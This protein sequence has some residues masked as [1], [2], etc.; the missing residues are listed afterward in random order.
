MPARAQ[1]QDASLRP[2]QGP[3][4]LSRWA[5]ALLVAAAVW[6][7][8]SLAAS[9]A[10]RIAYPY[11]LEWMEGAMLAHALRVAEG[12]PLYA[13]PSLEFV[14]FAYVPV[15]PAVVALLSRG[16]GL[17]YV[18]A[19]AVSLGGF[20]LALAAAYAFLRAERSPREIALAGVA[21]PAAAFAP[22][23]ARF[24]LARLDSLFL[25]L[26]AAGL[27]LAWR[28]R[29][30]DGAAVASA[31]VLA[32]AFFTKQTAAPLIVVAA[33]ALRLADRR[34][35]SIFMATLLVAGGTAFALLQAR[36]DGWFAT[37]A[38]GL[39]QRHAF[40]TRA[41]LLVTPLRVGLLLGPGLALVPWAWRTRRS[42][43]L[44]YALALAAAGLAASVLGAGTEWAYNN[45]LIPAV[46]FGGLAIAMAAG[47]LAT[48]PA[49]GRAA[50]VAP[51]ATALSIVSAAG[52]LVWIADRVRPAAGLGL[53]VGYDP[54]PLWPSA[55]D[56]ARGDALVARLRAEPGGVFVPFHPFYPHLAGKPTSLHAMNLADLSRADLGTPRDLVDAIRNR[57]LGLIV[58]D[59][60]DGPAPEDE[61][62]RQALDQFPR[63]AGHYEVVERIDGP[64]VFSGAPVRPR[65]L[66]RPRPR[67]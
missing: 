37:Y 45:A 66:L 58:L 46:Y 27:V 21:L 51:L 4:P 50:W 20:A 41:A 43:A 3:L 9:V 63:L 35:G 12:R 31:L 5:R 60:E 1:L 22:T 11:D 29:H 55:E 59:E 53:P 56:R 19:R 26:A 67:P 2:A 64:R 15:Y 13:P 47:R 24:D 14:S 39:H 48:S 38:F 23:G 52:G 8:V 16:F 61:R 17:G 40:D 57:T 32:A 36:T 30:R 7:L 42:S 49:S 18:L 33:V 28:G 10:H 65:L 34:R 25:G 44:A 54:R 6:A 62:T